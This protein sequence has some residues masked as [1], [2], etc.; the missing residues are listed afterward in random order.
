MTT[1]PSRRSQQL[2]LGLSLL[3]ASGC[4][5][6][7][8]GGAAEQ[9]REL[10]RV[11]DEMENC[12]KSGDLLG[13]AR[14]YADDAVIIGPAGNTTHGRDAI[15]DYWQHFTDPVGW[16]LDLYTIEGSNAL[17][18]QRGRSTLEYKSNGE[19]RRSVVEYLLVWVR[20]P[21]G[22]LKIVLDAY[23]K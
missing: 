7:G 14:F 19:P 1:K 13:V 17:I 12:F 18:S 16:R 3:A 6:T 5:S 23:W 10:R 15:D 21:D 9:H 4:A 8:V 22:Q 2:F 20:Q 11:L